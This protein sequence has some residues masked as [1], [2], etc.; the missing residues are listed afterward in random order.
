MWPISY[1]SL[2]VHFHLFPWTFLIS[3]L[4]SCLTHSLFNSMLFNL[5]EFEWFWVLSLGLVSTFRPLWPEKM[6]VM[7][8]ILLNLWRRVLSTIPWSIFENVP[9]AFEKNRDFASSGWKSLSL[10]IYQFSPLD[11]GQ[12][13]MPQCLWWYFVWKA[14][15]LWQWG[16][17]IPYYNWVAVNISLEV[18]KIFFMCWGASMLGAYIYLQ[19]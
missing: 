1:G 17:G 9:C 5:H 3:S 4:I 13:S 12:C 6:R 14:V 11:V 8:S 15:H 2:Q 10:R 7:I 18:L 16:V 19:C